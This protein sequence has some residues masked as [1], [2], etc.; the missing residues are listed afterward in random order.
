[1]PDAR[2]IALLARGSVRRRPKPAKLRQ[3][4]RARLSRDAR[5]GQDFARTEAARGDR[6]EDRREISRSLRAVNRRYALLSCHVE[7]SETSLTI[8][9]R[10]RRRNVQR[11]F[12]TLR[13]TT[14]GVECPF[15][16]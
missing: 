3:A 7:R 10:C 16:I 12:A 13:M 6:R 14:F 2:F 15:G 4:I 1:M 11:S 9:G 5:L 8:S